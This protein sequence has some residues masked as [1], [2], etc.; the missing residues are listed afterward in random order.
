MWNRTI[1]LISAGIIVSWNMPA[2]VEPGARLWKTWVIPSGNALRLPPPPDAAGTANEIQ[3]LKA[4]IAGETGASLTQIRFWDTG[5]PG[6][7]WM[8][9]TE[10]LAVSEGLPTPMRTR[11]LS[12]VAAAIYDATVAAW[13]SKYAYMRQHPSDID[14]TI[15]TAIRRRIVRRILRTRRRSSG[16]RDGPHVSVSGPDGD[17]GGYGERGEPIT[18]SGRRRLSQRCERRHESRKPGGADGDSLCWHGRLQSGV[19]WIFP[20]CAGR[21]EQSHPGDAVGWDLAS[22]GAHGRQSISS[23]ARPPSDRTPRTRNMTP[24]RTCSG[25]TPRTTWLGSGNPASSNRGCKK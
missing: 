19:H 21:L 25:P 15:A 5:A 6:Y 11:A 1:A 22:L 10:Q 14:N 2:Q 4:S 12:L 18:H 13:D 7:R 23:A 3:S 8:E 20:D 17:A 24:T 16:R 9:L